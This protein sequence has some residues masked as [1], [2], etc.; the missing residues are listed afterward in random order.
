MHFLKENPKV[1]IWLIYILDEYANTRPGYSPEFWQE[2]QVL[3]ESFC[4]K[5]EADTSRALAYGRAPVPMPNVWGRQ[6]NQRRPQGPLPEQAF[7]GLRDLLQSG[8]SQHLN[9]P[10]WPLADK[11][12][13]TSADLSPKPAT[14]DFTPSTCHDTLIYLQI[15]PDNPDEGSTSAHPI[16]STISLSKTCNICFR[17]FSDKYGLKRHA[18]VHTGERQYIC[19]YCTKDYTQLSN[20]KFHHQRDHPKIEVPPEIQSIAAYDLY[21]KS[22][23]KKWM[24]YS[25]SQ[26][27]LTYPHS[28]GILRL[29]TWFFCVLILKI[30]YI[31]LN[32]INTARLSAFDNPISVGIFS[33]KVADYI[34]IP[35]TANWQQN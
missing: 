16:V 9:W 8:L 20:L 17:E 31:G 18:V 11:L 19:K 4:H 35:L 30:N 21:R 29:N 27:I 23:I 15:L 7:H 25:C 13:P 14:A 3:P 1:E 26:P 10:A 12:A 34:S 5:V 6:Y 28:Y 2:L 33:L 22:R 24:F 32:V